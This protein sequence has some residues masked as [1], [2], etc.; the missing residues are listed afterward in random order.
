MARPLHQSLI[1]DI[2]VYK[3]DGLMNGWMHGTAQKTNK[4]KCIPC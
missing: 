4:H 3:N 1:K 2:Y